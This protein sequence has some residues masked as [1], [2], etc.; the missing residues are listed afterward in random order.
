MQQ[1]QDL[2][3]FDKPNSDSRI[4]QIPLNLTLDLGNGTEVH[5]IYSPTFQFC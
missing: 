5:I 1:F 4:G 2:G 3:Y